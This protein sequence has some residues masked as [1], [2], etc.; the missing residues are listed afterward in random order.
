MALQANVNLHFKGSQLPWLPGAQ[1]YGQAGAFPGGMARNL[2][3]FAPHV[4]FAGSIDLLTQD[5]LWNPETSGGLLVA[6]RAEQA[7]E[8]VKQVPEA[9]VIGVARPGS[10]RIVVAP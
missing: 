1:E 3:Y 6:L 9:V 2:D 7:T 8:Y 10:G 4:A 5:L